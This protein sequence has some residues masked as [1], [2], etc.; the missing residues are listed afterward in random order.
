MKIQIPYFSKL[1]KNINSLILNNTEVVDCS[2]VIFDKGKVSKRW[3]YSQLGDN[4]PLNGRI[5]LITYYK[6]LRSVDHELLCCTDKDIYKYYN[7]NWIYITPIYK[8]GSAAASGTAVTGTATTWDTDWPDGQYYIKFGTDDPNES[9]I[10]I[11]WMTRT[12]AA[13]NLW[14][15][16]C[17]GNG[18]FVAVAGTGTGNRVMTS[19]DGITWTIRSSAADNSWQS[20]CYGNG[21]FV[22]VADTGVGNRVMT[23]PDGITWTIRASAADNGWQSICYG[24]GLFV[25]VAGTGTGNR[26]MTSP[27]GITWT[28]RSSAADYNWRSICYG[29]GL[30]VAVSSYGTGDRVMTSPDGITW[31]IRSSAADNRWRSICYG[32]GLFVAVSNTGTGNRVMTSPDGITWTIRASAAD[33]DW[34]SVC[35]GNGLF[36]AVAATGTG[37][38]VMTSPDG[39]TWTI[40]SSS[41]DNDWMSVCY[42]NG[43]FVAVSNTGTGNMIMTSQDLWYLIDSIDSTTGITLMEDAGTIADGDYVIRRCFNLS[44]TDDWRAAY[45][46]EPTGGLDELWAILSN[47]LEIWKYTGTGYVTDLDGTDLGAKFIISYY[48]HIL[49]ANCIDGANSLPQTIYWNNRGDPEDWAAGSYGYVDLIQGAGEITGIEILNQRLYVFKPDSMIEGYYTGLTSPAFIFN[50][51]KIYKSGC[52]NG[53]TIVN[54]GKMLIFLGLEH[55]TMF[56]GFQV[57][58]VDDD[59]S[60]SL[61]SNLNET[62]AYKNFAA[63]IAD[64]FLYCLFVTELEYT[65]PNKVYVYNYR[66]KVWS[67]WNLADFMRCVGEYNITNPITWESIP[68]GVRWIDYGGYWNISTLTAN[69]NRLAFGDVDGYVY[70]MDFL[71]YYDDGS[72]ISCYIDTKD[73]ESTDQEGVQIDK[74]MKLLKTMLTMESYLGDISIRCS[75]DFGATWSAAITFTQSDIMNYFQRWL[76][77]G[78]QLRFRIENIDNSQYDLINMIIE[79]SYSGRIN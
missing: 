70:N 71:I 55:V 48:D 18:L 36:V 68:D 27:D 73:F 25:A 76:R 37:N 56:D 43:L 14:Y 32:N 52:S 46:I 29:N 19:S 45:V 24:N 64:K 34:L 13:D 4:L 60:D 74:A 7:D 23:S 44:T 6:K 42:G 69:S 67:I 54:T 33:N 66:N 15:S 30:F 8:E 58:F 26:V 22:V 59:V 41:V 63:H 62:Y 47:G 79:Y 77:R 17:Y 3:G 20:I 31:T 65:D 21:L 75:I 49:I 1:R 28:I 35:Y 2:N 51:D 16:I 38:R 5:S 61:I 9:N 11:G 50:E 78:N 57:D 12:S 53:K 39:I 72:D 40:R 10:G